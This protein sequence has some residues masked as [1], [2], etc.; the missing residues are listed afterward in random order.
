M[1]PLRRVGKRGE[2]VF[3]KISWDDAL[4]EVA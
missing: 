3:E 2:G 1:Y 4:D